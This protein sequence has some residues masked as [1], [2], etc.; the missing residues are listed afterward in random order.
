MFLK[1]LSDRR[2][3]WID[4]WVENRLTGR[5]SHLNLRWDLLRPLILRGICRKPTS[6]AYITWMSHAVPYADNN[7]SLS[8]RLSDDPDALQDVWRIFEIEA[9]APWSYEEDAELAHG[10][11]D[12]PT[13][14]DKLAQQGLLDRQQVLDASLKAR[15]PGLRTAC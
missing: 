14:L 8:Q 11:E 10:R 13:A 7:G 2:P 1:I 6:D 12:W 15:A 5:H 9:A 3:A 4:K